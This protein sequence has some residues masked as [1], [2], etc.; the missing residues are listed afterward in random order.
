MVTPVIGTIGEKVDLLI[1]R[2]ATFGPFWIELV[3]ENNIPINLTGCVAAGSI[4][5]NIDDVDPA[6]RFTVDY[7]AV[8]GK[9]SYMLNKT[10]TLTMAYGI[11]L[12]DPTGK[13]FWDFEIIWSDGTT[14][15]LMYGDVTVFREITRE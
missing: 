14:S 4:R 15:P 2:G 5:K 10:D 9:I 8:N 11:T 3:D 13:H 7:D 12:K 1:R 6:A